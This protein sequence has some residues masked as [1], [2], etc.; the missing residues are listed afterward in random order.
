MEII[1]TDDNKEIA[2][3]ENRTIT[4]SA[5]VKPNKTYRTYKLNI[6]IAYIKLLT[7]KTA[8]MDKDYKPNTDFYFVEIHKQHYQIKE[9]ANAIEKPIKLRLPANYKKRTMAL[10]LPKNNMAYL[11]AYDTYLDVMDA[12]NQENYKKMLPFKP[13]P[14]KADLRLAFKINEETMTHNIELHIYIDADIPADFIAYVEKVNG[15]KPEWLETLL[16]DHN[17]DYLNSV[18]EKE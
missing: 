18:V 8:V 3:L 16:N 9:K 13:F 4:I 2:I 7:D 10:T 17:I 6:P 11:K 5:S 15:V 14:L 12:I 1:K